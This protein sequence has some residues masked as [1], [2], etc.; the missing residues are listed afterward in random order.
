M[1]TDAVQQ[2]LASL[3]IQIGIGMLWFDCI[4]QLG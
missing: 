4:C 2:V 3:C 1:A